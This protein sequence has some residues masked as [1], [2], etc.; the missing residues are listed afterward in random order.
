MDLRVYLY[1]LSNM[2]IQ[3][4]RNDDTT[5]VTI[6]NQITEIVGVVDNVKKRPYKCGDFSNIFDKGTTS[7]YRNVSQIYVDFRGDEKMPIDKSLR[8]NVEVFLKN[9]NLAEDLHL[10]ETDIVC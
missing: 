6:R 5:P 4:F 9:R 7:Y 2:Y 3:F 1:S 8:E 10:N